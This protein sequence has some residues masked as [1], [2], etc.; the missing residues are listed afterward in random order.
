MRQDSPYTLRLPL[1]VLP[2]N[3]EV[4]G[5]VSKQL[6]IKRVANSKR[7]RVMTTQQNASKWQAL[8]RVAKTSLTIGSDCTLRRQN[9]LTMSGEDDDIKLQRAS[10][11][12]LSDLEKLLPRLA[13]GRQHG[14]TTAPVRQYVREA[15]LY[16]ACAL[17]RFIHASTR[18]KTDYPNRLSPFRRILS[19]LTLI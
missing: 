14:S 19:F 10:S 2:C 15:D 13:R 9:F 17:V 18:I 6:H 12:L 7:W 16:R 11:A 1:C 3:L 8:S 4:L 5:V